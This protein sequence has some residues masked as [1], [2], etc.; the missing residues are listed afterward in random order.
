MKAKEEKQQ[1]HTE[2]EISEELNIEELMDVQGGIED[3]PEKKEHCG[4]GC[5]LGTGSA[6]EPD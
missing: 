2:E 1:Q 3:E 4:L 5:F 6:G